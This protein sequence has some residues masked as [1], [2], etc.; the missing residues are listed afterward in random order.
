MKSGFRL[1]GTILLFVGWF[2]LV[3]GGL[4]VAFTPSPH[5]PVLGWILLLAAAV[6]FFMTMDRWIKGAFSGILAVGTLNAFFCI[7]TGRLT[8]TSAPISHLHAVIM[9]ALFAGSTALSL[10]FRD[11]KLRVLDRVAIFIFVFCIFAGALYDEV[12][13]HHMGTQLE[14]ITL[15]LLSLGVG[16]SC[17]FMAWGYDRYQRFRD[18]DHAVTLTT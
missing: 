15:A 11:R 13:L 8:T 4:G 16:C 3:L 17:L 5:S 2:G 18:T 10:T 14:Q 6:I 9:T 7:V 12:K 1:T